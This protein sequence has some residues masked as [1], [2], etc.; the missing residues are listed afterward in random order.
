MTWNKSKNNKSK[1]SY[2]KPGAEAKVAPVRKQLDWSKFQQAIF[3]DCS[4]GVGNTI[5]SAGAGSSK[6]TSIVEALY[7]IPRNKSIIF[8][9][10]NSD[11]AKE[12]RSQVPDYVDA[13]TFHSFCFKIISNAFGT[14][15]V[16][17]YKNYNIVVS[18]V[19]DARETYELRENLL[20]AIGLCKNYL[21]ETSSEIEEVLDKHGI[22]CGGE[23]ER[24]EFIANIQK[25]M[26]LS[27]LQNKV[28]DFDDMI[29]FVAKFSL[30][31]PK[32]DHILVD[33]AQD[34]NKLQQVILLDMLHETSR[35]CVVGDRNQAI[36]G[37]RGADI[38][39]MDNL[40]T[41]LSAKELS[42]PIS[43]RCAK[44]IVEYANQLVPELKAWE[45]SPEGKVVNCSYQ[46]MHQNAAY[47]DF[48][49][50][51]TNA[52]LVG[53]C[54]SFLKEGRRANIL[55]KDIGNNLIFMIKNSKA[56]TVEGFLEWLE[57]W[58]NLQV[59]RLTSK[60]RDCTQVLDKYECLLAF[61][62]NALTL[63]EVKQNIQTI[64]SEKDDKSYIILSTTH[65]AKGLE[66]DRVW[67]LNKTYKPSK[68]G[69][70]KNLAYVAITRAKKELYVVC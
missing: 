39:S 68:G 34:L 64:F 15:K 43:Y 32:Y 1:F 49:L 7:H 14:V 47:G 65:K 36:Y 22:E 17:K 67:M 20:K 48:I 23:K 29:W 25:A 60:N 31:V 38:H 30:N 46:E 3:K 5:I 42:L 41:I 24:L 37:W 6:T 4:D 33:E 62:E 44:K 63:N 21:A 26:E 18:L 12:I 11:I 9:A 16:D 59:E 52:P 58:K 35:V 53:L 27:M 13:K 51:R 70:E 61:C 55:G 45:Q 28:I 10:F 57:N 50:S 66:R 2:K 56:E 54:F 40:K 69:E 19:G 8:L